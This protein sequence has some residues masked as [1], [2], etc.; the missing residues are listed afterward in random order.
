T[1]SGAAATLTLAN[2][3][4]GANALAADTYS[5]NLSG[6]LSL[7]MSG[8]GSLTLSGSNSYSGS[9]LVSSGSLVNGVANSLPTG[10]TL[11]VDGTG[12]FDLAGFSQ[13]VAGLS[14]GG[15]T[16]GILTD[17]GAAAT[18]TVTS[19]GANTFSGTI[20]SMNLAL[21]MQGGGT[22]TL[23]GD[24]TYAGGTS[25]TGLGSTV[26]ISSDANLGA[27]PTATTGGVS[28]ASGGTL[29]VTGSFTSD[30]SLA[31]G[32]GGGNLNVSANQ[33]FTASGNGT[34]S[35]N[36]GTLI[37]NSTGTTG[38]LELNAG[39]GSYGSAGDPLSITAASGT[40]TGTATV[41]GN[42]TIDSGATVSPGTSASSPGTLAFNT[43]TSTLVSGG[44]LD[45]DVTSAGTSSS[46]AS[47]GSAG[48]SWNLLAL[49][50]LAASGLSSDSQFNLTANSS[51][52]SNFSPGASYQWDIITM[53]G[54][55][56]SGLTAQD[57]NLNTTAFGA[58]PGS[59][60]I[61][62]GTMTGG[63]GY[64]AIDYSPAAVPEPG[65]MLLAGLAA[66]SMA[67]MG[68]R[69]R[70]RQVTV[71]HGDEKTVDDS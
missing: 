67:G 68:W 63:A 8:D 56:P 2:M 40:L 44:T 62:V 51:L 24:N 64:V 28:L 30:R 11:T 1:D 38:T 4:S 54:G 9:T 42:I 39:S 71:S 60:S 59:F 16:T 57:F 5:G 45:F 25:I 61:A 50:T 23:G 10:T 20:S 21:A 70:R 17:S 34:W 33:T 53:A 55:L 66:L 52:P 49:N 58:Q 22:L 18:L 47:I 35:D 27:T 31:V 48:S 7:V 26:S 65:S 43:G 36:G 15:V 32:S 41:L 69:Q 46:N 3:T 13:Q 37:L 19:A 12:T 29:A 6:S 14:D